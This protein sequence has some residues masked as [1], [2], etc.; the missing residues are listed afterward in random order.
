MVAAAATM[1]A[2]NF[3][4]KPLSTIALCNTW[5]NPAASAIAEPDMPE[6]D[7]I[8]D[9][10]HLPEPAW[11]MPDYGFGKPEDS[12]RNTSCIH[13]VPCQNEEGNRQQC[14]TRRGGIHSLGNI[15][16]R[17]ALPRPMKKTTA[18]RA[19]ATAMAR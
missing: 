3:G 17:E 7:H 8:G 6:K 1:A 18:V 14:K 15:V 12:A 10:G 4:L 13:E 11:D 19:M 16:K 9:D 5:P 2:E